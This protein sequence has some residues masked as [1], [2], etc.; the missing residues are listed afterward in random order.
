[1]N[2]RFGFLGFYL[3]P[4]RFMNEPQGASPGLSGYQ[5]WQVPVQP[6]S[7]ASALRLMWLEPFR[8]LALQVAR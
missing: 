4:M 7:P 8:S 6:P 5:A 3:S 1:M 2:R